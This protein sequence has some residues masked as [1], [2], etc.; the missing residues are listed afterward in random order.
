[1]GVWSA[2]AIDTVWPDSGL[3]QILVPMVGV[4]AGMI[5]AGMLDEQRVLR[6]GRVHAANAGFYLGLLGAFGVDLLADSPMRGLTAFERA[7]VYRASTTVGIGAGIGLAHATDALPGTGAFTLSGG[8][9]GALVG[10]AFDRGF[11]NGPR[12][13]TPG[14]G[15][16]V[17]GA[18]GALGAMV[19]ARWLRPTPAQTRWLDVGALVG[20]FAGFLVSVKAD[21]PQVVALASGLGCLAGGALGYVLGAPSSSTDGDRRH[22]TRRTTPTFQGVPGGAVVGLAL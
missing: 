8:V 13:E 17:G 11:R 12:F 2:V 1:L 4:G 22:L 5:T 7:S 19:S 21:E 14:A 20:F 6:R 3:V 9:W 18:V 16:L 15:M 10:A